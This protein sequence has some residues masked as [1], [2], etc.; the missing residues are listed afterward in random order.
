M[1]QGLRFSSGS[2][3]SVWIYCI[4][5][6][7]FQDACKVYAYKAWDA[8]TGAHDGIQHAVA[9]NE[10]AAAKGASFEGANPIAGHGHSH[11]AGGHG[12]SHAAG[13]H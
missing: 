7:L 9:A 12:H 8:W 5:W 6:F 4:V 2:C 11:A 1:M 3:V 13:G 10:P